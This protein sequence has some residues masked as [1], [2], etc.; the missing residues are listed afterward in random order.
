MSDENEDTLSISFL[1]VISCGLGAAVLLFLVLSIVQIKEPAQGTPSPGFIVAVFRL[2]PMHGERSLYIRPNVRISHE[3]G[4]WTELPLENRPNPPVGKISATEFP[5]NDPRS[6]RFAALN[7]RVKGGIYLT[8][9][10]FNSKD[11]LRA[12]SEGRGNN[13]PLAFSI[14][15]LK[16][17]QGK[18]KIDL[19]ANDLE[20]TWS[21]KREVFTAAGQLD[22]SAANQTLS[23]QGSDQSII[24]RFAT[25][26]VGPN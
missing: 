24:T 26:S 18:W 14:T 5:S 7:A 20:G 10:T 23:N 8:G 17:E 4:D 25:I 9:F 6:A 2:A 16:P 22:D 15:L 19:I 21:V 12:V 13:G 11:R 3:N 1:D